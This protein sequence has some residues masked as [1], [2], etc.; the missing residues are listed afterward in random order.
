MENEFNKER[1][2]GTKNNVVEASEKPQEI[3]IT[4][5]QTPQKPVHPKWWDVLGWLLRFLVALATLLKLL[6][7]RQD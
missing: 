6:K 3:R 5:E 7:D 2:E 4:V 1:L